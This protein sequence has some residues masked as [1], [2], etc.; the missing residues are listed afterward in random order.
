MQRGILFLTKPESTLANKL[1]QLSG[2]DLSNLVTKLNLAINAHEV[3][4][5]IEVN[6]EE[7]EALLDSLPI[8]NAKE[9]QS[10]KLLRNKLSEFIG[11]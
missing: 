3:V 4:S 9:E 10:Y 5:K 11:K 8:P 7:V 6:I 2:Q 1:A